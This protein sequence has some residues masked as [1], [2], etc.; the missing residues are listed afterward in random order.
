MGCDSDL[1]VICG[2]SSMRDIFWKENGGDGN[3][4]DRE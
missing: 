3:Q 2:T 1:T 4:R